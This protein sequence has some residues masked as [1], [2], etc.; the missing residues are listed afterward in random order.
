MLFDAH[1]RSN[2]L[3]TTVR[4]VPGND[5]NDDNDCRLDDQQS[6]RLLAVIIS[7]LNFR[8]PR[9]RGSD[10][11]APV[12]AALLDTPEIDARAVPFKPMSA[13]SRLPL[14]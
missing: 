8:R 3:A 9:L 13:R 4:C 5:F 14:A 6:Y 2:N 1:R 12:A 11:A 10:S 7:S